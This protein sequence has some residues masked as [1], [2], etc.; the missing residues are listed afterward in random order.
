[1]FKPRALK[2]YYGLMA[3]TIGLIIAELFLVRH[4]FP[5]VT[6]SSMVILIVGF[7]LAAFISLLIFFNG[8]Y[9]GKERS[10]YM[11]LIALG[12]KML[13][14]MVVALLFFLVLKNS[15]T[16][17]VV[18]FFILYL[19]FTFYVVRTFTGVLKKSQIKEI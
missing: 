11:T 14:C 6:V 4:L 10:V 9:S 17:S 7:T 16:G 1:M 13:L 12:A 15:S 5:S 3:L 2:Y 8:Y 18:L 19:A